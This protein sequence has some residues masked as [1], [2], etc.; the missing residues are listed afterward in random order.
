MRRRPRAV[1]LL[2]STDPSGAMVMALRRIEALRAR[3]AST[4]LTISRGNPRVPA[5][6]P[7]RGL[8]AAASL[9]GEVRIARAELV[10]S[11]SERTLATAAPRIRPGTRLV[12]FVHTD[13][14]L[15]FE[16]EP[17]MRTLP[18]VSAVVVPAQVDAAWFARSV[19]LPADRAIAL[20]DFTLPEQTYLGTALPKVVLAPGRLIPGSGVMELVEAFRQALP[21]LPGWQLRIAGWGPLHEALAE[22]VDA[23]GLASRIRLLGARHDLATDYL[24]AGVVV[25]LAAAEANGLPV[26]ESL[27]AGIPVIGASSVPA[28]QR[29]VRDGVNG[30]VQIGRAHV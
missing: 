26:L 22:F 20:D 8:L 27:T 10:V 17:I 24:N 16:S 3:L 13:P 23:H 6:S 7:L 11:T 30:L 15:A 1:W 21:V 12:H 2:D 29:N 19:G 5:G 9:S 14:M 18:R 25:R 4:P 28:V